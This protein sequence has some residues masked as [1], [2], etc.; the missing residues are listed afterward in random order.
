M[1]LEF[2]VS[3]CFF[4][5]LFF[6]CVCVREILH[7]TTKSNGHTIL[8]YSFIFENLLSPLFLSFFLSLQRRTN[9][10]DRV[11]TTSSRD[12][13]RRR[14]KKY[15]RKEARGLW[16]S[17]REEKEDIG[18]KSVLLACRVEATEAIERNERRGGQRSKRRRW[19]EREAGRRRR[20]RRLTSR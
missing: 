18:E 4:C 2:K 3:N 17:E 5:F 14:R 10:D 13:C 7:Q 6:L 11:K 15:S 19:K 1:S 20:W 16:S 8:H 12:K 9:D